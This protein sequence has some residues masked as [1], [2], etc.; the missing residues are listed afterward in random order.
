AHAYDRIAGGLC[1]T[2]MVPGGRGIL[3]PL[4]DRAAV[5]APVAGRIS[6][7]ADKRLVLAAR[8]VVSPQRERW[9]R[10]RVLRRFIRHRAP[11][12]AMRRCPGL[13]VVGRAHDEAASREHDH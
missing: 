8:D 5:T 9:H 2:G 4:E 6:R 13:L 1:M 11:A 12:A 3:L 7:L 10:H